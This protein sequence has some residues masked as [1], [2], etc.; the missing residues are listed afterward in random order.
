MIAAFSIRGAMGESLTLN[1]KIVIWANGQL[2]KRIWAQGVT[3]S[4]RARGTCW[5]FPEEALRQAGAM[6]SL[7]IAGGEIGPDDNYVWGDEVP[8]KD[9]QPGDILQLRNHVVTWITERV[10]EKGTHTQPFRTEHRPHHSAIFIG[11]GE[12]PTTLN[13]LEQ[14]LLTE[15]G[16]VQNGTIETANRT[17]GETK[18][19]LEEAKLPNGR[20][21]SVIVLTTVSIQV[22]GE[23]PDRRRV[24][25]FQMWAYRPRA[26]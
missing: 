11:R 26:K 21:R 1:Q 23:A 6:T 15:Q 20:P 17:I 2:G 25:P 12:T 8:L 19:T 22:S 14:G 4:K 9:L 7:D 24:R 5:H 13:V 16:N 3:P 10:D 18:K